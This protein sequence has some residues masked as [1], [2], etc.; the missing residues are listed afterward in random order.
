MEI[1]DEF[2][3]VKAAR[4]LYEE[5]AV[6]LR[7]TI[8]A[9]NAATGEARTTDAQYAAEN[10]VKIKF[11]LQSELGISSGGQVASSLFDLLK[12]RPTVLGLGASAPSPDPKQ[13][14][15]FRKQ[16]DAKL[17]YIT[18]FDERGRSLFESDDAVDR[19]SNDT[20]GSIDNLLP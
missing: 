14:L 7:L 4:Q 10:L 15:E 11:T 12:L 20:R 8:Y 1:V 2:I 19:Y 18:N 17:G 13:L 3:S 6:C 16:L 9:A 5:L